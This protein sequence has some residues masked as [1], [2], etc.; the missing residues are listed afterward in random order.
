M[1]DQ[2]VIGFNDPHSAYHS[3][4]SIPPGGEDGIR[5]ACSGGIGADGRPLLA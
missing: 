4:D 2:V 3:A 5:V 1:V